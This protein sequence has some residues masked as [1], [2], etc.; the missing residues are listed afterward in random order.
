MEPKSF[1]NNDVT[2]QICFM[3]CHVVSLPD[4]SS[5]RHVAILGR[6]Q[7]DMP[8]RH[9]RKQRR[10]DGTVSAADF[11]VLCISHYC[12]QSLDVIIWQKNTRVGGKAINEREKKEE[13][14][15]S[16][17]EVISTGVF[18]LFSLVCTCPASM[19]RCVRCIYGGAHTEVKR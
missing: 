14:G 10:G 7:P 17:A 9:Q 5:P 11:V 6:K 4:S 1:R 2:E 19:H 3:N 18:C 16:A 12:S 8:W 13:E 15:E